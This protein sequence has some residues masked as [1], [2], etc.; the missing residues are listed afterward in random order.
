MRRLANEDELLGRE[1]Q[2]GTG[3]S[4]RRLPQAEGESP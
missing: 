1:E 4:A 2:R 3:R